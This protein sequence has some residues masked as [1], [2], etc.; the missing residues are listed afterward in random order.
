MT[1][2]EYVREGHGTI[3]R[4]SQDTRLAYTTVHNIV[5]RR[6]RA[7]WDTAK[8]IAAVTNGLCS[9]EDICD[10]ELAADAVIDDSEEAALEGSDD[11]S[12]GAAL[13]K[14]SA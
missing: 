4:I 2:D 7:R 6:H 5:H 8:K 14:E 10:V 13:Q 3:S 11:E 1:L 12:A 9:T